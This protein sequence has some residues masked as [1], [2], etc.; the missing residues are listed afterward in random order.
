MRLNHLLIYP[1]ILSLNLAGSA[2]QAERAER[3][4]RFRA[5][6]VHIHE[7]DGK[8]VCFAAAR[9]N[10]LQPKS[11]KREYVRAYISTW[12]GARDAT[13]EGDKG[14]ALEVSI[15]VGTTLKSGDGASVHIDGR[16][17]ALFGEGQTAFVADRAREKALVRAM[18][19]GKTMIVKAPTRNGPATRDVFS[20]SGVAAALKKMK[21]VC[22]Q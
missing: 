2:A 1:L 5:W 3:I 19:K 9:P 7:F 6:T 18:Q 10:K 22:E 20:L 21:K 8:T 17:F 14:P 12:K 13:S 16:R 15:L 11:L 4:K